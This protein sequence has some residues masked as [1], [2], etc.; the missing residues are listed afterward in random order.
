MGR[1]QDWLKFDTSM[2][3]NYSF[4]ALLLFWFPKVY[5]LSIELLVC[6]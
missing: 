2:V 6:E 3:H 4:G 1:I 5:T